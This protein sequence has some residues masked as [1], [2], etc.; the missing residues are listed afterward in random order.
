MLDTRARARARVMHTILYTYILF[1]Y[2]VL[3]TL[4]YAMS[5]RKIIEIK[6]NKKKMMYIIYIFQ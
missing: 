6:R 2:I 1:K 4:K 3:K 5:I